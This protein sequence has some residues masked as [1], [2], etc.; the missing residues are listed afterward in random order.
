MV[1]NLYLFLHKIQP[2]PIVVPSYPRAGIKIWTNLNLHFS[3]QMDRILRR[4][5]KDMNRSKIQPLPLWPHSSSRGSWF[6]QR[7]STLPENAFIQVSALI[8][9]LFLC[10]L[11]PPPPLYIGAALLLPREYDLNKSVYCSIIMINFRKYCT[12]YKTITASV[13]MF[14]IFALN[15]FYPNKKT[16]CNLN[17]FHFLNC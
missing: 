14:F 15:Q 16:R 13:F 10:K 7:E 1:S 8:E 11:L 9:D 4:F 3:G 12:D 6:E 2:L 17:L 5:F